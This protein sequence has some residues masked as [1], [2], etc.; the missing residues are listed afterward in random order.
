MIM[1]QSGHDWMA[2]IYDHVSEWTWLDDIILSTKKYNT[3]LPKIN[4]YIHT[5]IYIQTFLFNYV[6]Y[7]SFCLF[8]FKLTL[9]TWYYKLSTDWIAMTYDHVSEWT[10]L[11][12]YDIW[13]CVRVDMTG[14]LWHDH[15]S[16]W[17]WL[18]GYDIWS[19]LRVD[20]TGWLWHITMCQTN[21]NVIV[22]GFI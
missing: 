16:E 22:F 7:S 12:G 21:T 5:Y 6:R 17:T 10:W 4:M 11:D 2:M 3:S 20:M 19:C 1:C 14:W 15:M 13:S 8:R 18:D 9:L